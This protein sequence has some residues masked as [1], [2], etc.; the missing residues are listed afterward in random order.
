MKKAIYFS[1]EFN[2]FNP[3]SSAACITYDAKEGFTFIE[4][5][6]QVF[7]V[8]ETDS[9]QNSEIEL[10]KT[11]IRDL[12][13]QVGG[14]S[15]ETTDA[16][17]V[18]TV[19]T[20]KLD[21]NINYTNKNVDI[22][23]VSITA[24]KSVSAEN[25]AISNLTSTAAGLTI[26]SK[27]EVVLDTVSI[28]GTFKTNTNQ[29]AVKSAKS[30]VINDSNISASGYNGL[31]IGLDEFTVIPNNILIEKINFTGSY[32]LA[33][34]TFGSL[35]NNTTIVIKDCTFDACSCPIRFFNQ[36]NAKGIT[37]L[38]ENCHFENWTGE[39]ILFEENGNVLCDDNST[40]AIWQIAKDNAAANGVVLLKKGDELPGEF[41]ENEDGTTSPVVLEA[42]ETGA[43]PS[44][45]KR[46]FPYLLEYEDVANR[47]GK[48]KMTIT[49]KNCTYGSDKKPLIFT[50][51]KYAEICGSNTDAQLFF[52][53]RQSARATFNVWN[54]NW[55]AN[56]D[57]SFPYAD[58]VTYIGDYIEEITWTQTNKNSDCWPTIIFK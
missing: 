55:P 51:D 27:N 49:F 38:I 39:L 25:V 7:V 32:T 24:A 4:N 15:F 21:S 42:D 48:D 45:V 12:K 36:T 33:T 14:G 34:I 6:K 29:I 50:T 53:L 37:L 31:M 10:L 40:K 3:A 56:T 20:N 46:V 26:N 8:S 43:S 35:E 2:P 28:D 11:E 17:G 30:I 22:I 41:I 44:Y 57:L 52:I 19:T 13:L 54:E 58:D 47:F 9:K 1:D 16:D 5:G 18:I 23:N